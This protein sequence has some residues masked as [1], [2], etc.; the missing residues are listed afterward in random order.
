V[1]GGKAH[2]LSKDLKVLSHD[3]GD[4]NFALLE[5]PGTRRI[6][7]VS[8]AALRLCRPASKKSL[9]TY[10]IINQLLQPKHRN[11]F[12]L[13]LQQPQD[14]LP[15]QLKRQHRLVSRVDGQP[16]LLNLP[17]GDRRAFHVGSLLGE[18]LGRV[19]GGDSE[20][21]EVLEDVVVFGVDLDLNRREDL[22]SPSLPAEEVG[23]E[24]GHEGLW[25]FGRRKEEGEEE[26]V[27]FEDPRRGRRVRDGK[28]NLEK[29]GN[30]DSSESDAFLHLKDYGRKKG[31]RS[32]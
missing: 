27:N 13:V 1:E 18:L 4:S 25:G 12:H 24:I 32:V 22:D 7:R 14:R 17:R 10:L 21:L 6:G 20:V 28:T 26:Y 19:R 9:N 31:T 15:L 8:I 2:V 16:E 29:Q 5:G 23:G 3:D 30:V 11:R